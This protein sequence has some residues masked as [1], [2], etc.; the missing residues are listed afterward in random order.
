MFFYCSVF[1]IIDVFLSHESTDKLI[2]DILNSALVPLFSSRS[3]LFFCLLLK[4]SIFWD[5]SYISVVECLASIFNVFNLKF[6]I[7][8]NVHHSTH[9]THFILLLIFSSCSFEIAII[10]TPDTLQFQFPEI[11]QSAFGFSYYALFCL[12]T[13]LEFLLLPLETVMC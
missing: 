11:C 4:I 1:W 3:S 13:H 9:I 12:L 10:V 6:R 2:N 8:R 5:L 7:L